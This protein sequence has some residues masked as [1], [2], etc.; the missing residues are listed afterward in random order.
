MTAQYWDDRYATIGGTA[1]SWF[2]SWPETS[3]R[4]IGAVS[5]GAPIVD[6]GGGASGLVGALQRAGHTNLTVVDLS[7]EAIEQGL[8]RT[9]DP[10]SITTIVTDVRTW[11][12]ST[13]YQ[14]WHDRAAY[15][16]L[17]DRADQQD[18]WNK[19]RACVPSGGSVVIST[20]AEDG[21]E[22]CS[23][24]PVTRYSP[25]ELTAAMGAGFTVT[26]SEREIHITPSGAEQRFIWLIA[27]R[28]D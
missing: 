13:Q 15:H 27:K 18:Y 24:L 11:H 23:G 5:L 14:V 12:P 17:T 16:F 10:G 7:A 20:F 25:E 3:L 28:T 8:E 4:L 21:P 26:H 1:V 9:D 19:V 2:Q 6:V 22:K